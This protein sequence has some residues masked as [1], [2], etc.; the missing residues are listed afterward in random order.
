MQRRSFLKNTIGTLLYAGLTSN[1]SLASVVNSMSDD[2]MD[3][4]LYL[5]QHKNGDWKVK[6]TKWTDIKS[7]RLSPHYYNLESFKPLEIVDFTKTKSVKE[8]YWKQYNCKGRLQHV[9]Y[10]SSYKSGLKAKESGQFINACKNGGY[11]T[12]KMYPTYWKEH[13]KHIGN[14]NKES[15]HLDNLHITHGKYLGKRYGKLGAQK[16]L[17][18]KLGIHSASKQQR[19]EWA[20]IGGKIGGKIRASKT[21]MKKL[22]KLGN[23][24]NIKKY[25]KKLFAF[26]KKTFENIE[27][28]SIGQAEK[29]CDVQ[30][31]IITKIL[32]G[33]QPHTRSGWVFNKK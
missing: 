9:N 28:D 1:K 21:D 10:V 24:S 3:I 17:E 6:G 31:C 29:Y 33:L 32:R 19:T 13:G 2:S 26:N 7:A 30:S 23:E 22:S 5:I 12:H 20:T 18:N 25:G 16:V 8:K 15:G 14:K 27:F 11:A 4:L